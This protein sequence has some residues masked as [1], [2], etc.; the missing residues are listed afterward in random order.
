MFGV[1]PP[2]MIVL[3]IIALLLFG[4]RLPEVARSL[5]KGITEFKKGMH[6]IEDE[7]QSASRSATVSSSSSRPQVDDDEQ[8]WKAPRFE[9]PTSEP[10]A[11]TSPKAE[12]EAHA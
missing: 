9:P 12:S 11:E 6:G 7:I 8:Q 2:E 10:K 5:G 1:G 4:K 3:G